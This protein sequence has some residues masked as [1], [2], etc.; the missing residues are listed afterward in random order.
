MNLGFRISK[1][2]VGKCGFEK[3]KIGISIVDMSDHYRDLRIMAFQFWFK[4]GFAI[5]YKLKVK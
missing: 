1:I 2:T 3:N 4:K 5:Y